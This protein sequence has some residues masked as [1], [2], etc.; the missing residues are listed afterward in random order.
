MVVVEPTRPSVHN[1]IVCTLCSCYPW[2]VLGL[3]PTWYKSAPYRARVVAE[4]RA[5]LAEFGL[6]LPDE[7]RDPRLGLDRRGALHRAADAARRARTGM[8]EEELAGAGHARLD[9]RDRRADGAGAGMRCATDP[10]LDVARPAALE[11]RAGVRGAVA[12]AGARDGRRRRCGRSAS[13]WSSGATRSPRRSTSTAT[14]RTR[15]PPPRTTRRGSRRSSGCWPSAASPPDHSLRRAT[16]RSRARACA[17]PG[18]GSRRR[19][20]GGAA[21]R[22]APLELDV[23]LGAVAV[24]A[25]RAVVGVL[26]CMRRCTATAS[27]GQPL[28]WAYSVVVIAVHAPSADSSSAYGSGPR[29]CPTGCGSSATSSWSAGLDGHRDAVQRP[30]GDV[31]HS[32]I[33]RPPILSPMSEPILPLTAPDD[34][35]RWSSRRRRPDHVRRA[36]RRGRAARRTLVARGV[37]AGRHGRVLD[38]ERARRS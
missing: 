17:P 5:V 9:D 23:H 35:S 29:S 10:L 33:L 14:S 25:A 27:S 22:P 3:P 8:S 7:H 12:G 16:T 19:A 6:E 34:R 15:I 1:V 11:R 30:H 24:A 20:A 18:T 26:S 21:R 28:R 2:P 38:G 36:A 37:D 31:C 4:P 13:A 32:G